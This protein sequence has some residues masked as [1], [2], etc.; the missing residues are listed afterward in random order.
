MEKERVGVVFKFFAK[1]SVAAIRITEGSLRP[2][3]RIQFQGATT[4]FVMTIESME[5]DREPVSSAGA[6]QS[7][8]IQVPERVRPN[9]AVY[10]VHGED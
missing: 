4:D 2:G 9:D 6:G 8:G 10:L 5:I 3:D 1:P 7:V